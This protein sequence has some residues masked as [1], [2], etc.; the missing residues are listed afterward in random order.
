[1]FRNDEEEYLK[2]IPQRAATPVR[3]SV[4]SSAKITSELSD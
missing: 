1:M 2:G 3:G 4:E